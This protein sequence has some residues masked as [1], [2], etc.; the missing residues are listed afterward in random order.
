MSS[1]FVLL[2][3]G[4]LQ[5]AQG[6]QQLAQGT[7][8]KLAPLVVTDGGSD[9]VEFNQNVLGVREQVL[10]LAEVDHGLYPC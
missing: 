5:I 8:A 9:C 2:F 3:P 7:V 1:A 4:V 6:V 10:E